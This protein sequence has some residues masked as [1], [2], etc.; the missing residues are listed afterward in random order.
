MF[1]DFEQ[2]QRLRAIWS[3]VRIERSVETGLF[4][5]GDSDLPYFLVTSHGEDQQVRIRRGTVTISRARIITPDTAH[6]EF[7]NFF[8]EADDL[9]L[10]DFLMARSAAFSNLRL[11]NDS[12]PERIVTDTV[13]EAVDKL[14][15]QLDDEEEEQVAI[16][17]AP[18]AFSGF[19]VF[20]YA[21]ERILSS[22]PGNIQELRERGFLP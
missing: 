6:P 18:A 7:R 21:T 13:D 8:E 12:G 17:S 16:L 1:D 14:N 19:A 9:G 15:R 4:T 11:V 10:I 3:E 22:A 2:F 5:F 20:R